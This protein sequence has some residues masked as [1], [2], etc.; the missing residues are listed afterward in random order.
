M[1]ISYNDDEK[2]YLFLSMFD[3]AIQKQFELLKHFNTPS[4]FLNKFFYY[5][6]EI[7]NIFIKG[8]KAESQA[9]G[10]ECKY[11]KIVDEMKKAINE[12]VLE[13]FINNLNKKNIFVLTPC[14]EGYP[15]KLLDLEYYPLTLFCIGDKSLLKTD[16]LGVVG[17]RTP[18][19]YG[20]IITEKFCKGLCENDFTIVSGLAAGIDS[21]AHRT[22]LDNGGKTIAVLGGGF[23]HI[24]PAFN[25]EMARKIAKEGLLISEYKPSTQPTLYTFP[26]RNRIIAG[27]SLG[28]LITEAGEK[29]GALHTKEF[30]LDLGREVFAVPGNINSIMSV[31]TNRLIKS[32]QVACV[33]SYEDIVCNF[34]EN[35]VKFH[36]VLNNQ[37]SMEDQIIIKSLEQGE[38]TIEQLIEITGIKVGKLNANLTMLEI[39]GI[40]KQ[41]PGNYYILV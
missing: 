20:K 34:K 5:V 33:L 13:N 31:G 39:K 8:M 38:K 11:H 41:L 14:S 10:K 25:K 23:E 26:Q 2:V 27:L 9:K 18:T 29:S 19:Q 21:I 16:C 1:E 7:N 32:A 6:E 24:F 15:K 30:A 35:V 36:S 4:E 28:V 17:T 37:L 40:V 12:N 22:A 3:I